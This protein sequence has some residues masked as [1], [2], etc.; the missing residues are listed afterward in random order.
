M[1]KWFVFTFGFGLLPFAFAILFH[2]LHD[3]AARLV[4]SSPELLFFA[5]VVAASETGELAGIFA[6]VP[7]KRRL[8][9]LAFAMLLLIAVLSAALYGAYVSH[10]YMSPARGRGFD[11]GALVDGGRLEGDGIGKILSLAAPLVRPCT[12]W[13]AFADRLFRL[14]VVMASAAAVL[15]TLSEWFRPRDGGQR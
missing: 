1:T 5:L 8:Q 9:G 10:Q 2:Y 14:S 13:L 4:E 6:V 12:E 7:W 11:C 3:P 15:G